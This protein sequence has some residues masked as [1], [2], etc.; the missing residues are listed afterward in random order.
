VE[1]RRFSA[2]SA[3]KKGIAALA[4][5]AQIGL[6]RFEHRDRSQFLGG[7]ALQALR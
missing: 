1:E 6:Q 3:F 2:A 5:E 4:A 7:A